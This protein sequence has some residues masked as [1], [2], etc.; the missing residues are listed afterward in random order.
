LLSGRWASAHW[1]LGF[2]AVMFAIVLYFYVQKAMGGGDIKILTVAFLWVGIGCAFPFAVLLAVCAALHAAAAKFGWADVQEVG[3][4]KRIPLALSVA[5]AMTLLPLGLS[6]AGR[7]DAVVPLLLVLVIPTFDYSEHQGS[8]FR[9]QRSK[10]RCN[11]RPQIG[12]LTC[13]V[14][15]WLRL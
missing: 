8:N 11:L 1:N 4:R 14:S 5:A 9:F 2:A 3:G 10:K 7:S 12:R 15:F 6:A 13:N